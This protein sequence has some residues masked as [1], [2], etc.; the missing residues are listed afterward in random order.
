MRVVGLV[1]AVTIATITG[2][3]AAGP[4]NTYSNEATARSRCGA[5]GV[6]WANT[7]THVLHEPGTANYGKTRNGW[8]MCRTAAI[9]NGYSPAK[10]NQ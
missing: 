7:E 6:V 3:M 8:Y 1:V 4:P 2:V 10:N 5:D 9:K